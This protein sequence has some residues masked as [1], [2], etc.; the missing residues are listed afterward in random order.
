M[1]F[2]NYRK[3]MLPSLIV[4]A[5]CIFTGF[6]VQEKTNTVTGL[7][8]D[9]AFILQKAYYGEISVEDAE[10]QLFTVE[11]QPLLKEDITLLRNADFCQLDM[12]DRLE[13]SGLMQKM[14]M[15]ENISFQGHLTW[16]MKGLSGDYVSESDY[17]I[18][19][20]STS[21]QWKLSQFSPLGE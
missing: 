9:R 16:Y 17:Y 4:I 21:G 8:T 1:L 18:L 20:K 6:G 15:F 2:L 5:V 12:I 14:S 3:L 13:V 19:L 11:T 10:A 7:L